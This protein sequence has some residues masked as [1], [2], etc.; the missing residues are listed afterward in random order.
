MTW[1][2]E[3]SDVVVLLSLLF[4]LDMH[5]N[6]FVEQKLDTSFHDKNATAVGK[7]P[8]RLG[9]PHDQTSPHNVITADSG[10]HLPRKSCGNH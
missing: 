8:Q 5:R 6:E 1:R 2:T 3:Q 7:M 4:L 10:R 9:I